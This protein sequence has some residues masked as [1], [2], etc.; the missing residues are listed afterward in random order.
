MEQKRL[1][2]EARESLPV[3][4]EA[5]DQYLREK[6]VLLDEV[7]TLMAA[8]P[9]IAGL[10]GGN[11]ISMMQDNHRNH[12]DFMGTVFKFSSFEMLVKTVPWV[13][14]SY[15]AHGFSP[16]YFPLEL[17][18]WKRAVA[19]HLAP[20]A[21][22]EINA[23]YDWLIKNHG[24]MIDLSLVIP[25]KEDPRPE[26]R[27]ARRTFRDCLLAADFQAGFQLAESILAGKDGQE[28][29]YLGL[30]QPVMYEIGRLWEQDEIS[31]AEEHLA[32][33]VVA[34]ILAGLYARLP[35]AAAVRGKAVVTCAPNEYHE[36]GGRMLADMLEAAGWDVLFLGANTPAEEL[37]KLVRKNNPRF[38]AISLTMPFSIDKVA[39]IIA[40][41]RST[42]DLNQIKVLVGGSAF[43]ADHTLW[44]KIGADAWAPDPQ[45]AIQQ[46]QAW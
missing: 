5:A 40:R 28:A 20:Q 4:P 34:R 14:R 12:I 45:A 29:L 19:A 35:L 16:D 24:N 3:S 42:P 25:G 30:I 26:L 46:V 1:I 39:A 2:E 6:E 10:I 37:I 9:Q 36:L 15:T 41:L 18:T 43:N 7:N 21:A 22:E 33:S 31:T 17:A 44:R 23:V 27:D 13:Y 8:Q 11:A 38:L 32:T